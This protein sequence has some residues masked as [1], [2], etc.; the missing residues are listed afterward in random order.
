MISPKG[1]ITSGACKSPHSIEISSWSTFGEALL[2]S[3]QFPL[4]WRQ[5]DNI[6]SYPFNRCRDNLM[7][8][9]LLFL[10]F[11][12]SKTVFGIVYVSFKRCGDNWRRNHLWVNEYPRST[13]IPGSQEVIY[14]CLSHWHSNVPMV[15][16]I[17]LKS[18]N[19]SQ[20]SKCFMLNRGM[21]GRKHCFL[22]PIP[23]YFLL[24][25]LALQ[26]QR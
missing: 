18:A 25:F 11:F 15:P 7:Q 20:R 24:S 1:L 17:N 12:F 6:C 3:F 5:K 22:L 9:L 8:S 2:L 4:G 14:C 26:Y 16:E 10:L 23:P 13:E 19:Q 21:H